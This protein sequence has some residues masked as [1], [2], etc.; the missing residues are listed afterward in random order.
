[1]AGTLCLSLSE[2]E[3]GGRREKGE[4]S[5]FPRWLHLYDNNKSSTKS[6]EKD[7]KR[8]HQKGEVNSGFN[9]GWCYL[10]QQKQGHKLPVLHI[11]IRGKKSRAEEAKPRESP[12]GKW[13]VLFT[14]IYGVN[15]PIFCANCKKHPPLYLEQQFFVPFHDDDDLMMFF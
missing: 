1:M 14:V 3:Y 4:S 9:W 13:S 7:R 5:F 10:A 6:K 2:E 8:D 11:K 12:P 15:L